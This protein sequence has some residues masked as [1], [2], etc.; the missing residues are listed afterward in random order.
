MDPNKRITASKALK[1]DW[2]K[3]NP[4]MMEL[5]QQYMESQVYAFQYPGRIKHVG[6]EK[7]TFV[8]EFESET[9]E[10]HCK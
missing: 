1:H 6:I 3:D 5:D 7:I 2:F 10:N 9:A 8:S 4:L